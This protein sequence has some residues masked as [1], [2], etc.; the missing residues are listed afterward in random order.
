MA[1]TLQIELVAADRIVWSG[2]ARM[3]LT[4][5]VDGELGIMANH[6]PLL[7][8]LSIGTVDIRGEDG[9]HL[10]AAVDGGFI[11]VAKNRVSILSGRVEVSDEIDVEAARRDREAAES[12]TDEDEAADA[13]A[14]ADA[15]IA[16]YEKAS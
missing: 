2:E 10:V 14:L 4:R 3:V 15:R 12:M 16:A 1:A 11:S 5:T 8:V 7:S 13:V 9:E 6:T